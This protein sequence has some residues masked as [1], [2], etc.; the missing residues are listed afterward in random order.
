MPPQLLNGA[1]NPENATMY[2]PWVINVQLLSLCIASFAFMTEWTRAHFRYKSCSGS[3][4]P[5]TNST[6][7]PPPPLPCPFRH[8]IILF[9]LD[10]CPFIVRM[11]IKCIHGTCCQG[12]YQMHS[13]YLLP[14]I[15]SFLER[16]SFK[17]ETSVPVY[18]LKV[19]MGSLFPASPWGVMVAE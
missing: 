16:V 9:L 1:Y 4:L 8:I 11:S 6:C 7:Y 3:I 13:Q 12:L 10:R 18:L 5:R 19:L 2:V 17:G 14:S 15:V